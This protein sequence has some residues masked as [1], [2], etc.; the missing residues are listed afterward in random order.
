MTSDQQPNTPPTTTLPTEAP[1]E[2]S[3]TQVDKAPDADSASRA[4]GNTTVVHDPSS[5][6]V[7]TEDPNLVTDTVPEVE[8]MKVFYAFAGGGMG[9]VNMT[10]CSV[11]SALVKEDGQDNHTQWHRNGAS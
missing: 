9:G 5:D 7:D 3:D 10:L 11:C 4:H 1:V 6:L 2:I 8:E